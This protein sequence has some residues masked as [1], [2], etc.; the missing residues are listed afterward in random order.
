MKASSESGLCATVIVRVFGEL[1]VLL[2][3]IVYWK[4]FGT[5]VVSNNLDCEFGCAREG[6]AGTSTLREILDASRLRR[7]RSPSLFRQTQK[8]TVRIAL[9][10]GRRYVPRLR[11]TKFRSRTGAIRR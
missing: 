6:E 4:H 3:I 5:A 1:A 2:G 9:P 11:A 8:D 10:G 7:L